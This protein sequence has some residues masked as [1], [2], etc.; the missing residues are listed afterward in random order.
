METYK[1]T[2]ARLSVM[3]VDELLEMLQRVVDELDE[4]DVLEQGE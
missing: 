2:R 3:T 4:R 1:S